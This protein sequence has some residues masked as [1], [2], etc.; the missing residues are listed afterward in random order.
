VSFAGFALAAAAAGPTFWSSPRA[1]ACRARFEE[2]RMATTVRKRGKRRGEAV[3]RRPPGEA[4]REANRPEDRVP[5][6]A[7]T[8]RP[9]ER[10]DRGRLERPSGR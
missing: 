2:A 1:G 10:P 8:K 9:I 6:D 5:L 4:E 3:E 7:R